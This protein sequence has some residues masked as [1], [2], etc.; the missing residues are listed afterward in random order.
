[1]IPNRKMTLD[2]KIE[3]ILFHRGEP[4]SIKKLSEILGLSEDAVKEAMKDLRI[5]LEGRGLSLVEHAEKVMLGTNP[6]L[7]E[8]IA[9]INKEELNREL[10]KAGL[11]TLSIILYKGPINKKE[12]DYIRGVNSSYIIRNL[13]IRGLV[14]KTEGRGR[15]NSYQPTME[16]LA[17]MN[18]KKIEDLPE[19]ESTKKEMEDMNI[20]KPETT[21]G[22]D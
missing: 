12:I 11:E 5:K 7:S 21:A 9:E 6:V 14:E 10:G 4:V 2:A 20:A 22:N 13:L 3:A 8:L 16:L 18:L 17:F 15:G 19:F 1:L